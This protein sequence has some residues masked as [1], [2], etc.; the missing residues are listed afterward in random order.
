MGHHAISATHAKSLEVVREREIGPRASC[1]VG[2]AAAVDEYALAMLRGRVE[3]T[4]QAGGQ[5]DTVRGRVN[6]A[7][8][9]GDPLIVRRA[10]AIARD[11]VIVDADRAASDLD[12]GLVDELRRPD[13]AVALTF[14]ETAEPVTGVLVVDPGELWRRS[15]EEA[16]DADL[17]F[18]SPLDREATALIGGALG[19]GSRVA[20]W[21]KLH[22]DPQTPAVVALAHD[23]GH[24]V[25]PAPGLSPIAG[26]LAVAGLPIGRLAIVD[27]RARAGHLQAGTCRAALS[28]RGDRVAAWLLGADRGLVALD[29]GTQREEY[30]P[31]RAG[32]GVEVPGG[33]ARTAVVVAA[34]AGPAQQLDP[35]TAVLIEALIERGASARDVVRALQRGAGLSRRAAYELVTALQTSAN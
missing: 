15:D 18:R 27:G 34:A 2:V 11:A 30:R 6:P 12:R 35:A 26:A 1:I 24:A 5:T 25:L 3:L 28:V 21:A 8:R 33:R 22:S 32:E 14:R 29:V 19:R 7:F 17:S 23:A 13:A 9:P 31:W 10:P 4:I 16:I 20:L